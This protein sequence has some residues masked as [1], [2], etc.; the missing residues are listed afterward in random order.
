[1]EERIVKAIELFVLFLDVLGYIV[2]FLE[3][4]IQMFR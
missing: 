1:M 2:K 4:I 3:V